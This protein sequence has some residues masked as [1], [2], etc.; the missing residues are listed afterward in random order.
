MT[1]A[2][3]VKDYAAWCKRCNVGVGENEVVC[4]CCH[5]RDECLLLSDGPEIYPQDTYYVFLWKMPDLKTGAIKK[6]VGISYF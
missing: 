3:G 6:V 2:N 1:I 4:P 5:Q